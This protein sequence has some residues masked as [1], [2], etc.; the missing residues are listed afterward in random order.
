MSI[1]PFKSNKLFGHMRH[2][3][4]KEGKQKMARGGNPPCARS[5]TC[6]PE[7][8]RMLLGVGTTRRH[9]KVL[10]ERF[11][12]KTFLDEFRRSTDITSKERDFVDGLMPPSTDRPTE[13]RKMGPFS[14]R[15]MSPPTLRRSEQGGV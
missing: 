3:G 12:S 1:F 9:S 8:M 6:A 5:H 14:M 4:V 2:A 15:M 13:S 11:R 7:C 10:Q